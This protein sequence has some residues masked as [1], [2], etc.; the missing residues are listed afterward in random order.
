METV[1]QHGIVFVRAHR[2]L[3]PVTFC[4]L[5]QDSFTSPRGI[6]PLHRVTF[7]SARAGIRHARTG[8]TITCGPR[9]DGRFH[10]ESTK[11]SAVSVP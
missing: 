7:F 3:G 2:E 11:L 9:D 6:P 10:E 1:L 4:N 8:Q 5:P